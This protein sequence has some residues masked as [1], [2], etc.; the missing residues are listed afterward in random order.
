MSTLAL[1]VKL[2]LRSLSIFEGTHGYNYSAN[3]EKGWA[4]FTI[5][6]LLIYYLSYFIDSSNE[7]EELCFCLSN[8]KDYFTLL[9]YRD[10]WVISVGLAHSFLP[11]GF[12]NTH[13]WALLISNWVHFLSIPMW[14]FKILEYCDFIEWR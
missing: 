7:D 2:S 5:F 12:V 3:W 11:R 13:Q 8:L 10:L 14:E 1:S 6:V 9:I 4:N